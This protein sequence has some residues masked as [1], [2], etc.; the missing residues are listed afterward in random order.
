[1]STQQLP[2]KLQ[3]PGSSLGS[4]LAPGGG[5][6]GGGKGAHA[7]DLGG[8]SSLAFAE[9]R[10]RIAKG[11]GKGLKSDAGPEAAALEVEQAI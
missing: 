11:I 8:T 3:P 9:N 2:P 10:R 5:L 7:T 6:G 4:G 1:M